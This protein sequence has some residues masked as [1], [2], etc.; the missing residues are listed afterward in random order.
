VIKQVEGFRRWTVRG[1]EAV[2]TQWALI[3]T[4]FNLKKMHKAWATGQLALG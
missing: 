3:C 4:A 1:L 2:K